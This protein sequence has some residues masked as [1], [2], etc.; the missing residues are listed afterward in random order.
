[1]TILFLDDDAARRTRFL[2]EHP[3]AETVET[4]IECIEALASTEWDEVWLDH[5]LG[6]EVYV[7]TRNENTGSSVVRWIVEHKP[8]VG[9]FYVH[10]LNTPAAEGM[11]IDLTRA[12]YQAD[13]SWWVLRR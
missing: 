11:V 3:T 2:S 10:S 8:S 6:G 5:D 9:K 7:S 12:G 13:R 1:M 4:A